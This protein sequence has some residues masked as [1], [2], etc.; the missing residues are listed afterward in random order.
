MGLS[1]LKNLRI[2]I[3]GVIIFVAVF[4]AL[5]N[6]FHDLIWNLKNLLPLDLKDALYLVPFI[7]LGVIYHVTNFRSI[8]WNHYLRKVQTNIKE[9]L[10][11]PF[12]NDL[13]DEKVNHLMEGRKLMNIFY[14]FVDNTP[15][16]NVKSNLVRFN[17]LIWT[18]F[19]DLA[20]ICLFASIAMI[21]KL[22]FY[23]TNYNIFLLFAFPVIS[24]LSIGATIIVTKNHLDLSNEQLDMI[25][26]LRLNDLREKILED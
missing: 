20:G 22:F 12:R 18:S 15:S 11:N 7:V 9:T 6:H 5:P 3:P 2:L 16:I 13:T 4:I 21:V 10:I 23:N 24:L 25:L 8:I 17:G 19:I 1:T 26:H 14:H